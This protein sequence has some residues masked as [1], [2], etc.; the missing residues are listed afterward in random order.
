[1]RDSVHPGQSGRRCL[2]GL[3]AHLNE[4]GVGSI[5]E[6]FDAEAPNAPRGCIAQAGAW[7][8]RCAI[9]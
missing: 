9:W 1:L 7:R 2:D 4:W 8:R 5:G 3:I 6:I